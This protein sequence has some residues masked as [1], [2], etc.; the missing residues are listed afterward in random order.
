MSSLEL[1]YNCAPLTFFGL[2]DLVVLVSA[3]H[4]HVCGHLDDRKLVDLHELVCFRKRCT[5]HTGHLVVHP[6]VVLKRDG[7]EGLVLLLDANALFSLYGL[8]QTLRPAASLK[9]A[10]G[11]LI[12][13]LY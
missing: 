11:E 1:V 8:M 7:S 4:R 2:I 12:N 3:H 9:D 13:D 5:G 10:A 6:E